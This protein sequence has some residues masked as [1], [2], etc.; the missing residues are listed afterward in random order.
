MVNYAFF[1]PV[2]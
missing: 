2:D 1:V